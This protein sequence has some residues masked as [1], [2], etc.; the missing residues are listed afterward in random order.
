MLF[1]IAV[2]RQCRVTSAVRQGRMSFTTERVPLPALPAGAADGGGSASRE[3]GKRGK[4]C[5]P[6][7]NTHTERRLTRVFKNRQG[8]LVF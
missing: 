2:S 8:P 5:S 4:L 3:K 6:F 1:L 7:L